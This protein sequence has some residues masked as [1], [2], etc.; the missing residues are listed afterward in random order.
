[1][2]KEKFKSMPLGKKIQ[3]LI[4]YY[5]LAALAVIVTVCVIISFIKS[6]FFPAPAP[7]LRVF[8]YSSEVFD[9]DIKNLETEILN[10]T[11][12]D[13]EVSLIGSS[14]MYGNQAFVAR[15]TDPD[16]DIIMA[17][18]NETNQMMEGGRIV[19]FEK[20]GNLDLYMGTTENAREGQ[21]LDDVK[22]II[23]NTF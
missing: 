21:L 18:E 19:E 13:V 23:R 20:L 10:T 7:D 15:L 22:N 6:V 4:Q 5:G 14:D 8:V 1:M 3:W 17:P 11:G 12:M 2:D 16:L 9:D